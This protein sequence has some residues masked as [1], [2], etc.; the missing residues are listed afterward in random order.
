MRSVQFQIESLLDVIT[1]LLQKLDP[2]EARYFDKRIFSSI[3]KHHIDIV[4]DIEATVVEDAASIHEI[5]DDR[6]TVGSTYDKAT[7]NL[8]AD[9]KVKFGDQKVTGHESKRADNLNY[10]KI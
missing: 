6:D 2:E 1:F 4:N 7:I 3:A 9:S 10:D 5:L 8:I